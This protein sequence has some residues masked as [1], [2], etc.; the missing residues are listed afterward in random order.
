MNWPLS[1]EPA[2]GMSSPAPIHVSVMLDEVL[3]SFQPA[4]GQ[5]LVDGTLG[6]GGHTRALAER[7]GPDGF[8]LAL[9]RDAA[10]LE[11]AERNLAGLAV[12]IAAANYSEVGEVLKQLG[13]RTVDGILLDIGLSSDQ[14][15]DPTRGFSFDAEGDLDL[16]FDTDSGEPAWRLIQRLDAVELAN[17]I[18]QLGEERHSRRI[19][20]AIVERRDAGP[21]RSAKE[22]AELVRANVPRSPDTRRIDPATRTFQALRIA[23]NDELGSL[24]RALR[25]Y[26]NYLKPGGRLAVISFHSLEDRIVKEAFRDDLRW[27]VITRKPLRPSD[28]EVNRNPRARSAKLRVA[29]RK[30]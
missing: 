7:V 24:S 1:L 19:A 2:C 27:E 15:A 9:D 28:A 22:F 29:Q 26:P 25:D 12:K 20:R 18:Y 10:A 17:L 5:I 16:R 13:I 21:L 3:A 8:V 23:V 6:A 11:A 4:A 30:P 14:L